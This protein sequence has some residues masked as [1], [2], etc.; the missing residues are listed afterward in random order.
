MKY[1]LY[2]TVPDTEA[3][4]MDIDGL[5]NTVHEWLR[6]DGIEDPVVTPSFITA[7]NSLTVALADAVVDRHNVSYADVQAYVDANENLFDSVIGPAIDILEDRIVHRVRTSY[8]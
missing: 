8:P 6:T 3:A 2:I 1:L 5:A 4:E 7:D